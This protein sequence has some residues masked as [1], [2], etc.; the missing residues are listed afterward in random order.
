MPLQALTNLNQKS[1]QENYFQVHRQPCS[2][3]AVITGFS[4]LTIA[5]ASNCTSQRFNLP[6][7]TKEHVDAG[8]VINNHASISGDPSVRNYNTPRS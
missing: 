3:Q 8:H 6:F 7:F 5:Q 2:Y 1:I 4:L